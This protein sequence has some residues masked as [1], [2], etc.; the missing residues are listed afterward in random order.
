[1]KN[2]YEI[3]GVNKN[4]T[5]EQIRL[6]YIN[7][8]KKYHPD[9]NDEPGAAEKFIELKEAK[10][11]LLDPIKREEY[12][13]KFVAGGLGV[14]NGQ[15]SYLQ[16]NSISTANMNGAQQ[17]SNNRTR[18]VK[19]RKKSGGKFKAFLLAG[20]LL[21]GGYLLGANKEEVSTKL[22]S[23]AS[24][25]ITSC[26]A[27]DIKRNNDSI[28][29]IEDETEVKKVIS[30]EDAVSEYEKVLSSS[31]EN[32]KESLGTYFTSREDEEHLLDEENTINDIT[33]QALGIDKDQFD[34][35]SDETRA[36]LNQMSIDTVHNLIETATNEAYEAYRNLSEE[37]KA[38][39]D[40]DLF[41]RQYLIKINDA[42]VSI[43][44]LATIEAMHY[45]QL[46]ANTKTLKN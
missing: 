32:F 19:S 39:T 41:M 18:R 2:Y 27:D 21:I 44:T 28:E 16:G 42:E 43:E 29:I 25:T 20:L 38:I 12:D 31:D 22:N 11:I 45:M 4:A 26:A 40:F 14:I 9:I 15:N 7:L 5:Q 36:V 46:E 13:S 35:Y 23:C 3:L 30:E 37:E 34:S 10:E 1:M 33:I 6:A 17:T 8:A 24:T